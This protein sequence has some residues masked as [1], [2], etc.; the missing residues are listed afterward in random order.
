M[1]QIIH[2]LIVVTSV[3][4]VTACAVDGQDEQDTQST[5][6]ASEESKVGVVHLAPDTAAT[7]V[8]VTPDAFPASCSSGLVCLYQNNNFGGTE[9][10]MSAGVAI[11]SLGAFGFNDEMS[12]W[13]N[14]TSEQYCYWFNNNF[15]GKEVVMSPNTC[16]ASVLS[17]NNDQ[18]SS[19]GPC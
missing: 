17:S 2:A 14:H 5:Q 12:S 3:T 16:H 10:F 15:S 1:Q 13:C 6:P 18:A 8:T 7:T 4:A 9:V 19:V 11:S